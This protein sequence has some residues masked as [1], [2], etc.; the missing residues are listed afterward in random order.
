MSEYEYY[1]EMFTADGKYIIKNAEGEVVEAEPLARLDAF[2]KLD[3]LMGAPKKEEPEPEVE[4]EEVE[5]EEEEE[6]EEE[7]GEEEDVG[8]EE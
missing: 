8:E 4:E 7:E 1:L 5:E 6:L 3:E 2:K